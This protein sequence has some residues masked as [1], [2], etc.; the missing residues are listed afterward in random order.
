MTRPA[1]GEN[2]GV[3]TSSLKAS[4]PVADFSER[5]DCEA[6]GASRM[7]DACDASIVTISGSDAELASA[8]GSGAGAL[9]ITR[10]ARAM[11]LAIARRRTTRINARTRMFLR[12][13]CFGGVVGCGDAVA[14]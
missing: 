14:G 11:T 7:P 3:M 10:D 1:Y 6:A 8:A 9:F 12:A 4:L 2:T 13:T 5:K